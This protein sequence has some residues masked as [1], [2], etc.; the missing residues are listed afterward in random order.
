LQVPRRHG[1]PARTATVE[2]RWAQVTIQAPAV[3]PKKGWPPLSLWAVWVNEP[4]PPS[5]VEPLDWMLLTDIPVRTAE[6]AWEKAEWYCRRWGIE[7]W[8]RVLKSGCSIEQREFK[9]AEN[10]RR[11]LVFDLILAWRILALLKLGRAV[12]HVP[13]E[14]LYTAEEIKMLVRFAK[15]NSTEPSRS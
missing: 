9:T 6:E 11:V 3:G 4:N 7:E 13:A 14:L 8:H 15:K 1:Q 5:K 2:I 12:P 10:L